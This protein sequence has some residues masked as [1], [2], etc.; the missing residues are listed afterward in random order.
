MRLGP[1]ALALQEPH[2]NLRLVER[3]GH[4][5]LGSQKTLLSSASPPNKKSG[6]SGRF[7]EF[8]FDAVA[9][10][11][12]DVDQCIQCELV[13]AAFDQIVHARLG[14]AG[15]LGGLGPGNIGFVDDLADV[16]DQVSAQQ[17]ILRLGFREAQVAEDV[18]TAGENLK[19]CRHAAFLNSRGS[20]PSFLASSSTISTMEPSSA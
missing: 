1:A 8:E 19:W 7:G 6:R 4:H 11:G 16:Y 20:K 3:I 15:A 9:E 5:G 17:Q 2:R 12:R 18:V 14:D 13:G 10:T